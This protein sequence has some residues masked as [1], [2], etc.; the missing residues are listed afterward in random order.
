M[1]E[2]KENEIEEMIWLSWENHRRSRELAGALGVPLIIYTSFFKSGFSHIC[3]SLKTIIDIS[4]EK[5]KI[6]I[7]QNPSIV[8]AFVASIAKY[9]YKYRLIV[10]RHTNF[11]LGKRVGM[12]PL[13]ILYKF[14][15]EFSLRHADLTIVTN[16]YLK[17]VVE[18][19][20]GRA[21]VLLDKLPSFE[22][23]EKKLL[24]GEFKV[25]FI[26][27]Y[28]KDEPFEEVIQAAKLLPQ[29]TCIYVT[30][31]I[32]LKFKSQN[33]PKNV[34]LTDFLSES[35][36]AN[37]LFSADVIMDF[38]TLDWCLVCGGYEAISLRRPL[39]TSGTV[40]LRELFGEAAIYSNHSPGDIAVCINQAKKDYPDYLKKVELYHNEF[41]ICW[42]QQFSDL[43]ALLKQ[44]SAG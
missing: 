14:I 29:S 12:N 22:K 21:F 2:K 20:G 8:L 6:L 19:S 25:V 30:G 27:T 3:L 39:I 13:N 15:S 7:V 43:R 37:L 33:M 26:C 4:R 38:T 34:I 32:P 17:Q 18:D 1:T 44:F 42:N 24:L 41:V 11:R 40:A 31:K 36:F 35:D 9:L 28:A 16:E 5:P 10:D 23:V